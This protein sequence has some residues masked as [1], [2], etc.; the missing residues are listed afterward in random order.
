MPTSRVAEFPPP[1]PVLAGGER[2]VQQE[3]RTF[4]LLVSAFTIGLDM[5]G[6]PS[7]EL[8]TKEHEK[9]Y[10]RGEE[11]WCQLFCAPGGTSDAASPPPSA[12]VTKDAHRPEGLHAGRPLQRLR[13]DHRAAKNP[14]VDRDTPFNQLPTGTQPCAP[15]GRRRQC[16]PQDGLASTA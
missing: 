9:R 1:G 16:W 6:R 5:P 7:R 12:A 3:A 8:G 11:I 14:G 2:P 4:T 10:L 13:R 15:A